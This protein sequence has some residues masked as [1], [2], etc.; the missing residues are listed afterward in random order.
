VFPLLLLVDAEAP[1]LAVLEPPNPEK[2]RFAVDAAIP[3]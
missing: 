2:R 3:E 1:G